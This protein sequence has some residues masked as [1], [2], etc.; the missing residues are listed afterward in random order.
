[1][2]KR[3]KPRGRPAPAPRGG[4]SPLTPFYAILGVIALA[5]IG[6]LLY[7]VLGR[8]EPTIRPVPVAMDPGDLA[9]APGMA[10]GPEDAPVV[11]YEF[12]DFQ[13]PGCAQFATFIA[14]LIKERYVQTGV[15]RYVYYDFPLP[16]HPHSFLASRAS[17][18]AGEQDRF[19]EYHDML[20]GRQQRWSA[21]RNPTPLFIDFATDLG[22]DRRAFESCL[23]SDRFALEVTQNLRLGESLGVQGTPTLFING[24]RLPAVPSF[25]ELERLI[26][27]E[28]GGSP[29]AGAAEPTA[30]PDQTGRETPGIP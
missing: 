1:V 2:A 29:A 13:C 17:R 9:R 11:I 25:R 24:K 7:Q 10:L 5:G 19:W 22:L 3:Q 6:V 14:P 30:A 20:Y 18:C 21:E 8:A 23:R 15:V 28:I 16:N 27:E 12:A 4:R 26:E